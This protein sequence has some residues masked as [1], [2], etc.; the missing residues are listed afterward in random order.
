MKVIPYDPA[1]KK[2]FI[3]MNRQWIQEM[4]TLEPA[5]QVVLDHVEDALAGGGQIFFA[6]SE[7]GDALAC[8]MV[9]PREA[10]EWELEK[11]AARGMYTGS[12]AGSACLKACMDYAW[13][14]GADKLII[15][16]NRRCA[17]AVHLYRK[18]G[19]A[20]VPVDREKFPYQ[21]ADIAFSM[22]RAQSDRDPLY[23]RIQASFDSQNFLTLLGAT[24][25]RVERG[26]VVIS[27][28]RRED[29]TQQQG[30]L[31]GGVVTAIA[32]V[33]CGYT[34]LTMMPVGYEVLT[35]EFKINLLRAV[36]SEKITA[37]GSVVKAGKTLI[38]TEAEV[39]DPDTGKVLAKMLAT[40][41]PSKL[42]P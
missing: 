2:D 41:I 40:M 15:V 27:C 6:L 35:V 18:F 11:F 16:S 37:T 13:N 29:L 34:A 33:T 10:G 38:I 20:E 12:G 8:C 28:R 42:D 4:F 25:D 17:Q 23:R 3:A 5:D 31:H 21:R 22:T 14:Q 36:N 39:T 9:V 1:Y 26:R 19:F 24:L 30:L 32:D 7:A